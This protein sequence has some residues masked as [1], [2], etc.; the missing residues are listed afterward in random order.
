M[1]GVGGGRVARAAV[2]RLLRPRRAAA[3]VAAVQIAG[4]LQHHRA[5]AHLMELVGRG[6]RL[7]GVRGLVVGRESC[8]VRL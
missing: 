8:H 3:D 4:V 1:V 6:H 2:Q 7:P 5:E